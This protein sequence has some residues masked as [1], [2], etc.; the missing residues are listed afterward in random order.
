ML[1]YETKRTSSEVNI[2]RKHMQLVQ[3][4]LFA[5]EEVFLK[6]MHRHQKFSLIKMNDKSLRF[7]HML[8]ILDIFWLKQAAGH[9]AILGL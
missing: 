9:F 7:F 8:L 3:P 6:D 5:I 2:E 1:K 4:L